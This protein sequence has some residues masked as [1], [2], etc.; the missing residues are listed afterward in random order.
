MIF[1]TPRFLSPFGDICR[2]LSNVCSI[3]FLPVAVGGIPVCG[4]P[5]SLA[6]P[7]APHGAG[8]GRGLGWSKKKERLPTASAMRHR[9]AGGW[10]SPLHVL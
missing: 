6:L 7:P 3:A 10:E 2:I 5:V 9:S 1:F 4:Y 8:D